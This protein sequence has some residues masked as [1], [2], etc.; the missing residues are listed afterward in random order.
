MPLFSSNLIRES[1]TILAAIRSHTLWRRRSVLLLIRID[2]SYRGN[3]KNRLSP[4]VS[5]PTPPKK[6]K[7]RCASTYTTL[8]HTHGRLQS[9]TALGHPQDILINYEGALSTIHYTQSAGEITVLPP[10]AFRN[11]LG[12]RGHAR[13]RTESAHVCRQCG[14]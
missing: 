12:N 3:N 10:L 8:T 4:G 5:G 9:T 1:D 11:S 2:R 14:R 13:A 7:K 6:N